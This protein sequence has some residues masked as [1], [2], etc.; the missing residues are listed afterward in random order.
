MDAEDPY[1]RLS[2]RSR[3][4]LLAFEA[5]LER[6]PRSLITAVWEAVDRLGSGASPPH[7]P[8][9]LGGCGRG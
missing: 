6:F 1:A 5:E 8:G 4:E 9:A 7:G 2:L 3:L